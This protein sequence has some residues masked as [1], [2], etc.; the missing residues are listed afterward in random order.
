MGLNIK[1]LFGFNNPRPTKLVV[2]NKTRAPVAMPTSTT[3]YDSAKSSTNHV[4]ASAGEEGAGEQSPKRRSS[5]EV[6]Q[7]MLRKLN[8]I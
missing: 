1:A 4:P 8:V 5:A 3:S 6:V 2:R 7:K